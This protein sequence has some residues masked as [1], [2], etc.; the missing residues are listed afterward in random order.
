MRCIPLYYRYAARALCIAPLQGCILTRHCN[1]C[2]QCRIIR[3]ISL[4][5]R[6]AA[7][8]LCIAPLQ[9]CIL[10][11]HRVGIM[12]RYTV[13]V[14]VYQD[15]IERGGIGSGRIPAAIRS[16]LWHFLH[17]YRRARSPGLMQVS[18]SRLALSGN[19]NKWMLFLSHESET[20]S[21][22]PAYRRQ[23]QR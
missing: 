6:Y 7:R 14:Q 16:I 2:G 17:H 13:Y 23:S 11:R 8:A 21:G 18:A 5:Y 3:L 4:Y 22:R 20:V 1:D 15:C 9:G 10:T 12:T 19:R